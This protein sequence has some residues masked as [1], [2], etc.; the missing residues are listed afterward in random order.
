VNCRT[1]EV[2]AG[3]VFDDAMHTTEAFLFRRRTWQVSA[4]AW[5]GR[6]GDV[7]AD[8]INALPKYVASRTLGEADMTW[9]STLLPADDAI[10]GVAELRRRDG[11]DV[12]LS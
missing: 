9:G 8:T 12:F 7:F 5:P 11:G 10:G 6:S 3:A 4:A 2:G 1:D